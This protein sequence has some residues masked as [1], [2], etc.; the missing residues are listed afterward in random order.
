VYLIRIERPGS[1][2]V[3]RLK[4]YTDGERAHLRVL[5]PKAERLS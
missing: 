1:E 5:E 3:Y 2:K 4:V